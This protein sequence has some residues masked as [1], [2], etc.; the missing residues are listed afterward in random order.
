MKTKKELNIQI[1]ER[2]R[3]SRES[4]GLTQ[5]KLAEMIDVSIQYISDLERG[6][7]GTSI[8]TMIKL[9]ETLKVSSDYIL[10]GRTEK[11]DLSDIIE[12]L[13]FLSPNELQIAEK[14]INILL[15]ALS[16]R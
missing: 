16:C 10:L 3:C 7:V 12:R 14:G 4:S 1:G 9:C 5:E 15:E 2:I 13:R 6:V 8:P 11:N